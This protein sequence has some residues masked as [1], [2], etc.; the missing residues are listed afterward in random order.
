MVCYS[1]L[2]LLSTYFTPPDGTTVTDR[3]SVSPRPA[4]T[5]RPSRS[6]DGEVS[7]VRPEA[8]TAASSSSSRP[9]VRTS[10]APSFLLPSEV[11]VNIVCRSWSGRPA[12]AGC[13]PRPCA[14]VRRTPALG[15]SAGPAER[16]GRRAGREVAGTGVSLARVG[17]DCGEFGSRSRI[18]PGATAAESSTTGRVIDQLRA[19]GPV[20]RGTNRCVRVM[21]W[22]PGI[23]RSFRHG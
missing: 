13:P 6:V 14:R 16:N 22:T 8:G 9:S 15:G 19:G 12:E 23:A 10:T 4:A 18:V 20:T 3:P 1:G 2:P 21:G 17:D 11:Q 7:T 5:D